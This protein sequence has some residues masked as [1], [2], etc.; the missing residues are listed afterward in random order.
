MKKNTIL[1]LAVMTALNL[2]A[3][4]Y[5]SARPDSH[6]PINVMGDHT[7]NVGEWMVS[8]RYSYMEMNGLMNGDSSVPSSAVHND[9][10]FS[11]GAGMRKA[12]TK[13]DM[14]MQMI[15]IM[16][17]LTD[18]WTLMLMLMHHEKSM[19]SVNNADAV[20]TSE[21]EG[22]GDVR[23]SGMR[24]FYETEDAKAHF[25]VGLSLPTGA[26]DEK[27]A[28]GT[29]TLGY[30]MQLGS[31]TFDLLPGVTYLKQAETWSWG[32]QAHGTIRLGDNDHDYTLGNRLDTHLWTQKPMNDHLSL[33]ARLHSAVWGNVDG[34]D[35]TTNMRSMMPG[36][37]EDM[38][39]GF[40]TC[41]GLGAN[42]TLGNGHRLAFEFVKPLYQNYDGYQMERDWT[43]TLGWQY[44]W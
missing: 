19:E 14:H 16:H 18:E 7:H 24:K 32:A 29:R 37:R 27:N 5:S 3:H 34:Q 25:T 15:G 26:I 23:F 28:A 38:Q 13:M 4:E 42:Y 31:G 22:W 41:L 1:I 21:A 20:T 6:A 10:T 17:A 9:S 8:Y 12:P 2:N 33:G 30:P 43:L 39:G 44:A 11:A 40:V 36:G 35:N